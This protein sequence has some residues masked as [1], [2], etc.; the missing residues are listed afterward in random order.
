MLFRTAAVSPAVME[1]PGLAC[2]LKD[3]RSRKGKGLRFGP[4]TG[5]HTWWP[6]ASALLLECQ[7]KPVCHCRIWLQL[8]LMSKEADSLWS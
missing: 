4:G 5:V 1:Q 8:L 3:P 2:L 7:E 6:G